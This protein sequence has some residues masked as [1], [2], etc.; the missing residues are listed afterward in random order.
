MVPKSIREVTAALGPAAS[1]FPELPA[2]S[3]L[4]VLARNLDVDAMVEEHKRL[5]DAV[6]CR[7]DFARLVRALRCSRVVCVCVSVC[8]PMCPCVYVCMC[9]CMCRPLL[10]HGAV[11]GPLL[12][13]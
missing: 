9:M 13:L 5:D 12:R 11:R 2:A 6:Q 10:L 1:F 8:V 7:A 3:A 4:R